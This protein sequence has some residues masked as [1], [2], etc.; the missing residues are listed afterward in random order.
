MKLTKIRILLICCL[1]LFVVI[2]GCANPP[3]IIERPVTPSDKTPADL[4]LQGRLTPYS[5]MDSQ[6]GQM[7]S[8]A[9]G[10]KMAALRFLSENKVI[11]ALKAFHQQLEQRKDIRNRS[12]MTSGNRG[13]LTYSGEQ[14]HGFAWTSG[15][16]LFIGEAPNKD[17]LNSLLSSSRAG[18]H[19][20]K[21]ADNF[22]LKYFIWIFIA[23]FALSLPAI[24]F[25]MNL[26]VRWWSVPPN[27]GVA[28]VSGREL[29]NRILS[30]NDPA[31]PFR[32]IEDAKSDLVAEWKIV[33]A[34]WWGIFHKSGLRKAYRMRLV[35]DESK[36][37]VMALEEMGGIEWMGGAEG[38][39][40]KVHFQKT[41]FRGLIISKY[42]RGR[43][44]GLKSIS[45]LEIGKLYDYRFDVRD[46]KD[47][48]IATVIE[49]GWRFRPVLWPWQVRKRRL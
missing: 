25:L 31:R 32:I 6:T 35:L 3:T 16:W 5:F 10:S 36:R 24:Y 30:L 19:G 20:T 15:V 44:Y 12:I 48:V 49:A 14:L 39:T 33:D 45:P 8:L 26:I 28:P 7:V 42:E 9:D 41:F 21:G 18:G 23:I 1:M 47:P 29:Y 34:K 37:E 4:L 43:A 2:N 46:V 40:P 11:T 38:L 17:Q 13:Y 22:I 27:P